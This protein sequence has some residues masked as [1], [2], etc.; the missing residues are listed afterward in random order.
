MTFPVV[1][2][3]IRHENRLVICFSCLVLNRSNCLV[4]AQANVVGGIMGPSRMFMSECLGLCEYITF[5][6]KRDLAD[7]VM[8]RMLRQGDFLDQS[9]GASVNTEVLVSKRGRHSITV[10]VVQTVRDLISHFQ[11]CRWEQATSQGTQAALEVEKGKEMNLPQGL[12]KALTL[13][14]HVRL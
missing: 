6:G 3:S 9:H 12:Q 8:L 4:S 10:R 13:S 14:T 5:H 7:V 11:L 2:K 1:F